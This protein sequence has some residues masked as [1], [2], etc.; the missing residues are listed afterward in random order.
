MPKATLTPRQRAFVTEYL[1]SGN[2][3][4]SA[5]NAG[6]TPSTASERAVQLLRKESV[7]ALIA[8]AQSVSAARAG[9]S[10]DRIIEELAGIA[11]TNL[12]DI[13]EWDNGWA[14]AKASADLTPAEAAAIE[15]IKIKRRREPGSEWEVEEVQ[16]KLHDKQ[17]A[18]ELI[19]R[20]IGMWPRSTILQDNRRQ[21]LQLPPG[22]TIDD[23][24]RLRESLT[25]D[26]GDG[27][28]GA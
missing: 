20:A 18:L 27:S 19:G 9:I 1:A 12:R 21:T 25:V 13:I 3:T 5:I 22:T 26:A 14:S 10:Q 16:F 17:R 28:S 24:K 11:F 2:G 15:S 8:S 6:Y 7:A 4:Q 23:I